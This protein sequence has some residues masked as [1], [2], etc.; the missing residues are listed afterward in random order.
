VAEK[1]EEQ[2]KEFSDIFEIRFEPK[3][4]IEFTHVLKHY[5]DVVRSFTEES[6][7]QSFKK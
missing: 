2:G 6:L 4:I 5:D 3:H 7:L 1:I